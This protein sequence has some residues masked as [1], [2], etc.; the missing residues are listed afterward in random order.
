MPLFLITYPVI[1]HS[2][3]DLTLEVGDKSGVQQSNIRS[4]VY[5]HEISPEGYNPGREALASFIFI[6]VS[7]SFLYSS[8]ADG[9]YPVGKPFI[10]TWR[11]KTND[12]KDKSWGLRRADSESY[13]FFP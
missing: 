4:N 7:L 2:S 11:L 3:V 5:K 12:T 13:N 1:I 9:T 6:S 10:P 8:N